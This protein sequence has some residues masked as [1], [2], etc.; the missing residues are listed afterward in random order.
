MKKL[1]LTVCLLTVALGLGLV[2]C[3]NAP[4]G[5]EEPAQT[6]DKAE[7]TDASEE[8]T[9]GADPD[10]TT[11]DAETTDT[12][13]ED[14][15][16][17]TDP[18]ETVEDETTAETGLS[19]EEK[20]LDASKWD[21]YDWKTMLTSNMFYPFPMS[22]KQRSVPTDELINAIFCEENRGL[23]RL[24]DYRDPYVIWDESKLHSNELQKVYDDYGNM[25]VIT[26][27][28]YYEDWWLYNG[29]RELE[30]RE[31]AIPSLLEAYRTS[32][33]SDNFGEEKKNDGG[34]LLMQCLEVVLSQDVYL[35][36]MTDEEKATLYELIE[37]F[38]GADRS[39]FITEQIPVIDQS[40]RFYPYYPVSEE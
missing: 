35:D 21:E 39:G 16:S 4:M 38:H 23:F 34:Y 19:D 7:T 30:T 26:N 3:Q 9:R 12:A 28:N 29:F 20:Y 22:E 25:F 8:T 18:S 11:S 36:R 24:L 32:N 40:Y 14:T 5:S 17:E 13:E 1:K 27:Y 2:G 33:V 10:E 31:D 6:T 37:G 15:A